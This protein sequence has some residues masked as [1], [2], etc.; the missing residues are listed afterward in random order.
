MSRTTNFSQEIERLSRLKSVGILTSTV[1]TPGMS[2]F[3]LFAT[4]YEGQSL[5]APGKLI[6]DCIDLVIGELERLGLIDDCASCTKLYKVTDLDDDFWCP[7]CVLSRKNYV[8]E[9]EHKV[10]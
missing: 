2:G 10:D 7:F 9:F 8:D 1:L 3:K 4:T 6:G 5:M